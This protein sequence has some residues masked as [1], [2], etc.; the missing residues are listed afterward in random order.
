MNERAS[1]LKAAKYGMIIL[2]CLLA[3]SVF[4]HYVT[5]SRFTKVCE[6]ITIFAD[7]NHLQLPKY[8]DRICGE[9]LSDRL[10]D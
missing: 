10:S 1:A 5:G 4:F 3:L 9:R 7:T 8:T 6:D 2:L